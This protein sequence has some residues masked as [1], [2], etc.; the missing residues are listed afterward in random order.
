[1][2]STPGPFRAAGTGENL[3]VGSGTRTKVAQLDGWIAEKANFVEGT[4]P[5]VNPGGGVVGHWTQMVWRDTTAVGC[6][7]AFG[8]FQFSSGTFASSF[9]VCQYSPAGN[10]IGQPVF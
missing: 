3:A 7:Q 8:D 10:F 4:F 5:D 2:H 1:M 9:Y 6:G